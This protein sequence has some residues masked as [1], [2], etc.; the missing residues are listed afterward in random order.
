[1]MIGFVVADATTGVLL[2]RGT[3]ADQDFQH[4]ARA[5]ELVAQVDPGVPLDMQAKRMNV[6]T[7]AIT[8]WQ[9]PAPADDEWQT[10]AWDSGLRRYLA[11]PTVAAIA[12]AARAERDSRMQACDWV[13]A[14]AYE[15]G[16]PVPT[17]WADYRQALRDVTSQAGFPQAIDW[18]V[19]PAA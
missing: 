1:M 17:D 14:R 15:L 8:D 2:R 16:E 9:P 12:R 11:T 5:G 3:C 18:P 19:P 13:T 6:E 4:Q 10:W 7:G